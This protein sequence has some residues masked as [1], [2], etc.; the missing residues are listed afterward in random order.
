MRVTCSPSRASTR[1]FDPVTRRAPRTKVIERDLA[2][3]EPERGVRQRHAEGIHGKIKAGIRPVMQ[4]SVGPGRVLEDLPRDHNDERERDDREEAVWHPRKFK[5]KKP[6]ECATDNHTTQKMNGDVEPVEAPV[7][8]VF[9]RERM[10]CRQGKGEECDNGAGCG[11]HVA[12]CKLQTPT[13][14]RIGV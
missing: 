8:R 6:Y 14:K 7:K 13:Q 1:K 2:D 12:H 4:R 10:D 11:A 9:L 3:I 5:G